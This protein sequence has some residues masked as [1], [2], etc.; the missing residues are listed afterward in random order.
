MD[1][2]YER[3]LTLSVFQA[4]ALE[5]AEREARERAY[6]LRSPEEK[7]NDLTKKLLDD[8]EGALLH[9]VSPAAKG[10]T[11]AGSLSPEHDEACFRSFA[12]AARA[13]VS[14]H[15]FRSIG[16]FAAWL[17]ESLRAFQRVYAAPEIS[18]EEAALCHRSI[19]MIC[20]ITRFTFGTV[21]ALYPGK[22]T[23]EVLRIAAKHLS[24]PIDVE[25]PTLDG[26]LN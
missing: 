1:D 19:D 10:W 11:R 8:I 2:R 4:H 25:P 5:R 3:R 14:M 7:R 18:V 13:H 22:N 26:P 16:E 12:E 9:F 21:R 6:R 24:A 15:A 23:E 17:L 20:E